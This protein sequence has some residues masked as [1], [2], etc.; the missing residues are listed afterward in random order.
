MYVAVCDDDSV[1]REFEAALIRQWAEQNSLVV[2]IDVFS[3]AEN[4]LFEIEDR[5]IDYD[6]FILD[7]QMGKMNGVEL[8]RN[9]RKMGMN[10]TLV[11][12]TGVKDYA[13]EGYEV[14]AVRYLLKPLKEENLFSVLD[15]AYKTQKQQENDVFLLQIS[16]EIT[17]IP[18][19][20]IVYIEANGHY[21][22]LTGTDF[23]KEWKSSFSTVTEGLDARGFFLL[24]RGLLVNLDHVKRISRTECLLDNGTNLPVARNKYSELNESFINFYKEK[25]K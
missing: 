6:L 2:N 20:N 5:K 11:F 7:I 10:G 25:M 3:S 18:F 17:K 16:G 19:N 1:S 12:L 23:K 4:F 13:I 24:S 21:V 15:M 8:A 9:L 14:G 22:S